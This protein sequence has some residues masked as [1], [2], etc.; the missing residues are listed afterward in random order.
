MRIQAHDTAVLGS[1]E[2]YRFGSANDHQMPK[3]KLSRSQVSEAEI[4]SS[5]PTMGR[6]NGCLRLS[7]QRNAE[8]TERLFSGGEHS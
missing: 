8:A 1:L 7:S 5:V 4:D 6:G 3:H 2:R